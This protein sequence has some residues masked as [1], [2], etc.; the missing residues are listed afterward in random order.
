VSNVKGVPCE[1][2]SPTPYMHETMFVHF[3]KFETV[4]SNEQFVHHREISGFLVQGHF[5]IV[6]EELLK[7]VLVHEVSLVFTE[8]VHFIDHG[9]IN[10]RVNVVSR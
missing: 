2:S 8:L 10:L 1:L 4:L 5:E 7:H 3:L 6:S 9:R